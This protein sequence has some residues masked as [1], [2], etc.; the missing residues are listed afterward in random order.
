MYISSKWCYHI[1]SIGGLYE[2]LMAARQNKLDV[3]ETD[4]GFTEYIPLEDIKSGIIEVRLIRG[5]VI[6][7]RLIGGEVIEGRC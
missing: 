6:E 3:Q 1:I 2:S 7:G 5:G 4:E